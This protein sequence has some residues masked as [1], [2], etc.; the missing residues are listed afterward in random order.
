M[1]LQVQ[2]EAAAYAIHITSPLDDHEMSCLK[3]VLEKHGLSMKKE[4][5]TVLIYKP[6]A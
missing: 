4:A 6:I 2:G 5:N 1:P 3:D